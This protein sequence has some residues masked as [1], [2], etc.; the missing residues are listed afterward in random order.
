[1]VKQEYMCGRAVREALIGGVREI[2]A[3]VGRPVLRYACGVYYGEGMPQSIK[4]IA[5]NYDMLDRL[6]EKIWA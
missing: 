3:E 1:M 6:N 5:E 2:N 4:V